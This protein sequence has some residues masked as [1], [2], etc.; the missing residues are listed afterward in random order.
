[1]QI[2]PT[3]SIIAT[4][5][6]YNLLQYFSSEREINNLINLNID[7]N[8]IEFSPS[9]LLNRNLLTKEDY[10][11]RVEAIASISNAEGYHHLFNA[12]VEKEFR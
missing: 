5:E 4:F 10:N 8:K 6:K 2:L 1:M 3:R 11:A 12:L 7:P 9:L